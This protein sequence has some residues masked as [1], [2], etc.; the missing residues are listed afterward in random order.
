MDWRRLAEPQP[1][2]YDSDVALDI[3]TAAGYAPHSWPAGPTCFDGQ[4]AIG[5]DGPFVPG[6]EPADPEH[7]NIQRAC[8]LIGLWPAAYTQ[9]QRLLERISVY[10]DI[11][12]SE[13]RILGAASQI[14]SRG[15]GNI[16]ITVNNHVGA[17][18]GIVHELAHCKLQ[19]LGV[20]VEAASRLIVNPPDQLCKSPVRH[21]C[22]RPV[23]AVLHAQYSYT[24]VLAL[25]VAIVAAGLEAERDHAVVAGS[26]ARFLP[27][28][29]YGRSVL[30]REAELDDA[31]AP[32]LDGLFEWHTRLRDAGSELLERYGVEAVP[33]HH[34]L[35]DAA[36]SSLDE[37]LAAL[38]FRPTPRAD[39]QSYAVSDEMVVFCPATQAAFALNSASR[40][41]WELCDGERSIAD[42]AFAIGRDLGLQAD[43]EVLRQLARDVGQA[44][45]QFRQDGLLEET[46]APDEG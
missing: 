30:E 32:F 18:E 29:D 8:D 31:G 11:S 39:L 35:D 41:I 45:D 27:M 36:E 33:F 2:A 24:Y 1:D 4:V 14:G 37:R 46:A 34:P 22:L 20:D 44:V 43:T 9:C 13:D 6:S 5:D 40:T 3:I 23:T 25:D 19:A 38:P 17:A 10:R 12:H 16:K 28:L 26:I 15:F 42:I 21:D 7:P